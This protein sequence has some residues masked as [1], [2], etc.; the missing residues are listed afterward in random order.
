M[1]RKLLAV[2]VSS[3]FLMTSIAAS[4]AAPATPAPTPAAASQT[5]ST[6]A[7]TTKNQPPLP[8]GR[9]INKAQGEEYSDLGPGVIIA[10]IAVATGLLVWLMFHDDDD[11]SSSST[12]T[13]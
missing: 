11:D 6:T 9:A 4:A 12:G 10:G 8:P 5:A 13:N 2:F 3:A 7:T 1:S